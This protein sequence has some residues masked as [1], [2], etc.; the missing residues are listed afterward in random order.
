MSL[1]SLNLSYNRLEVL[2]EDWAR[3]RLRETLESVELQ[4]NNLLELP[5]SFSEME[6]VRK[7]ILDSNPMR[8]PPDMLLCE[9]LAP[10]WT[11]IGQRAARVCEIVA[12]FVGAGFDVKEAFLAPETRGFVT[13]TIGYMSPDD[14]TEVDAR[15]DSYVNGSF[16][17]CPLSADDIVEAADLRRYERLLEA[18]GH[19]VQGMTSLL[20]ERGEGPFVGSGAVCRVD[21]EDSGTTAAFN[22]T[23]W[24]RKPWGFEGEMVNCTVVTCEAILGDADADADDGA[25]VFEEMVSRPV[26]PEMWY[27]LLLLLLLATTTLYSLTRPASHQVRLGAVGH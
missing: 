11:Y 27:V 20:V 12:K 10:V 3:P 6:N 25:S 24:L 5:R 17:N 8:S 2:A 18:M 19:V 23:S 26:L 1:V 21:N 22:G 16:Y 4:F 15:C 14:L 9:G 13:G 7:I